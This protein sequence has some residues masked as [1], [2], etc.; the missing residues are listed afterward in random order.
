MK[1]VT[2]IDNADRVTF[3][4]L[5]RLTD[6]R[7]ILE[8][9]KGRH[10]RFSFGYCTDDN[11][12][13]AVASLHDG[14]RSFGSEILGRIA[15]NFIHDAVDE[16]G[17]VRN[18]LSFQR[19]WVDSPSTDDC[20][21]RALWAFGTAARL[22]FND[23]IRI[24][25]Q[26]AFDHACLHRGSALRAMC[27]AALG[28]AEVA[29]IDP[30]HHDAAFL[31]HDAAE[32]VCDL[33]RSDR[34]WPWPEDRL[35]YHNALIPEALL[36]AGEGTG[37]VDYI[38]TG[39]DLLEWLVRRETHNGR[40]SVTPVGGRGPSDP[41]PAFDQQPIEVAG[42]ANASARAWHLTNDNHWLDSL[43]L[44]TAWFRGHNDAG[45]AMVDNQSHGGFDGLGSGGV[46]LNQGAESTIAMISTL[47][48]EQLLQAAH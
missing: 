46:N 23:H 15:L 41:Q 13:L 34:A 19:V 40:L 27:Y 29:R 35:T 32:E 33:V 3:R 20:W 26:R 28:A 14:G 7:G 4:H 36:A 44:A 11:A 47:Q 21:G 5:S 12:R 22:G 25:A 16:S 2:A 39:L 18:R 9:A 31:L 38:E 48:H 24:E 17:M 1:S 8:H 45:L 42:I 6:D 10:P 43:A 30:H 37:S